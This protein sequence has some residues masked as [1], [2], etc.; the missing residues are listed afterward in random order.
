MVP[1]PIKTKTFT[2]FSAVFTNIDGAIV[3]CLPWKDEK[4]YRTSDWMHNQIGAIASLPK[5]GIPILVI[6]PTGV[7][8][9]GL[10]KLDECRCPIPIPL[11]P[12][13]ESNQ[14]K[15]YALMKAF[16]DDFIKKVIENQN[17]RLIQVTSVL[18]D[19][20]AFTS[21]ELR[22]NQLEQA[23]RAKETLKDLCSKYEEGII[24]RSEGGDGGYFI[25]NMNIPSIEVLSYAV[26]V[27]K[28]FSR[29][30]QE[31]E[32]S[33]PSVRISIDCGTVGYGISVSDWR[34]STFIGPPLNICS[35]I[36]H[37]ANDN[38]IIVTERFY[39]ML[40]AEELP[41]WFDKPET[42]EGKRGE[43]YTV[44]RFTINY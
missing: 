42:V 19:I 6:N 12:Q 23:D 40:H 39:N 22:K 43:K 28:E 10:S 16:F 32:S 30:A 9:G 35:R 8:V 29:R 37:Y 34:R 11:E 15:A 17:T 25:F 14:S 5:P 27:G 13:N 44:R 21:Q 20:V 33:F 26:S 1:P 3:L 4:P 38:G 2:D 36:N 7:D 41:G 24:H 31:P 18:I